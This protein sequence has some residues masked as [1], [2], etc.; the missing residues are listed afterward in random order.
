[1]AD[2]PLLTNFICEPDPAN[3]GWLR[4]QIEDS[5]RF[6]EA[7]LG[8]QLLRAESDTSARLRINPQIPLHTNSAGNVHG[9]IT[10]ALADVSLFAAMYALRGLDA[11]RAVTLDLTAQFIGSGDASRPLDA[12]VELLRE[13]R[14]FAFLRGLVV[15]DDDVVASFTAAIRKPS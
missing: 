13:T 5:A 6:N 2:A 12:V 10:L 1:M 9:A 3:P 14:R 11:G 7:V 4:W 8:K 15:Q